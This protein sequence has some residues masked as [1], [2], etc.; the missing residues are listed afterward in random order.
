M[1]FS[2][3]NDDWAKLDD[4]ILT[5]IQCLDTA[6]QMGRESE[7]CDILVQLQRDDEKISI[8][9]KRKRRRSDEDNK[10]K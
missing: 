8:P 9:W 4:N 2:R 6:R 1:Q 5:S 3:E 7:L 10:P